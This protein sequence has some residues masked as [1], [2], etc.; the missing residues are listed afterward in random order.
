ML[1]HANQLDASAA[2]RP[3]GVNAAS[4]RARRE[5][6]LGGRGLRRPVAGTHAR[7][8][9]GA[10]LGA[11]RRASRRLAVA[12]RRARRGRPDDAAVLLAV[13]AAIS[14][15]LGL[16]AYYRGMAIGAMAVVAPIAGAS[17]IVP[18]V[19]GIADRRPP[20]G[21]PVRG[22]RV[23]AR[24]RRARLAGA[25]GGRQRRAGRGRR[26][27]RCSR[28]SG[29]ASTSR[30]CTPPARPT[31]S[32]ASLV[33]RTTSALIIVARRRWSG[34]RR[35]RLGGL[36]ARRSSLAVGLGDTLGNFLFAAAA[37]QGGLVSLTSVLASLYPIVTVMLAAVVLHE[38]VARWQRVG[39]VLTLAGVVLIAPDEP[40]SALS[41]RQTLK[42]MFSTSPSRTTYVLPSRRWW[43]RRAT[44][45]CEPASTSSPSRRPR[46]G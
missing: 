1:Y 35:V 17:A 43:P 10:A 4:A 32:W 8:A 15:T 42:R 11:G 5:P 34:G 41:A 22:D 33:F 31:R 25:P 37:P 20:V 40:C 9:A 2:T 46:S 23:R 45:A 38:R 39:I 27:W 28:R 24:R 30:P 14:G 13:P 12:A 19:F 36:D 29:S 16:Y 44:S 6:R 3:I 18:V 26:A 7:G 21:V